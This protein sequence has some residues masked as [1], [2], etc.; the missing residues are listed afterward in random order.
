M[1]ADTIHE[2]ESLMQR[3]AL[4]RAQKSEVAALRLISRVLGPLPFPLNPINVIALAT[5]KG[6]EF[7]RITRDYDLK[8]FLAAVSRPSRIGHVPEILDREDLS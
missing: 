2:I 4:D 8:S 7:T 1:I 5:A 3:A 6:V